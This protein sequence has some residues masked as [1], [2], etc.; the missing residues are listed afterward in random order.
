MANTFRLKRSAVAG[1]APAIADLQLGELAVNTYDGKL[2]VKKN[3]NGVESIVDVGG[4]V[5]TH[6]HSYLPLSGG[7][8]TGATTFSN[9]TATTSATTGAVVV[10]GGMGVGGS[11]YAAGNVTAYSD[12]RLKKNWRALD[13]DLVE[14]LATVKAGVFDRIDTGE[15][16]VGVSAQSL[17]KLLP[18]AVVGDQVLAVA[19]GNAA[20]VC[21][22]ALAQEVVALRARLDELERVR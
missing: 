11:I 13:Q 17:Q 20:M 8:V 12:E 5:P 19:Y 15:K 10:S 7:T 2:F 1:K 22:V 9:A 21:C 18:E 14:R 16:Q 4:T 6:T 3:V